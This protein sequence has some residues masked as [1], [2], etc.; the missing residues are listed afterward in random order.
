MH[1][2]LHHML[3]GFSSNSKSL[4]HIA[5]SFIKKKKKKK[6]FDTM[7]YHRDVVIEDVY[8]CLFVFAE[9]VERKVWIPRKKGRQRKGCRKATLMC[10]GCAVRQRC[11]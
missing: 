8:Y 11:L 1:A 9:V 10:W 2:S 3:S 4:R 7:H 5:L 6:V